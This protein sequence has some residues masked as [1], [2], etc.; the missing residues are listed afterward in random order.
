[1]REAGIYAGNLIPRGLQVETAA[2]PTECTGTK[3]MGHGYLSQA[4][5]PN[6]TI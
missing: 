4:H 2:Y 3:C 1:M 6:E 5:S